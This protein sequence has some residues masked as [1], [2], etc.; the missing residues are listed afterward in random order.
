MHIL[1]GDGDCLSWPWG[2]YVSLALKIYMS[3]ALK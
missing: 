1:A 3:L 2:N